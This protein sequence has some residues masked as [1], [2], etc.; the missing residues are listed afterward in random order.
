MLKL[1]K[2]A[3]WIGSDDSDMSDNQLQSTRNS[4]LQGANCIILCIQVN[5]GLSPQRV[6]LQLWK[7]LLYKQLTTRLLR[8]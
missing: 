8:T 7:L 5:R 6:R 2:K 4:S 1:P 3:Y